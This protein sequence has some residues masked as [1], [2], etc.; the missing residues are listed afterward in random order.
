MR[1]RHLAA[2]FDL[3]A[4]IG[5]GELG[6]QVQGFWINRLDIARRIHMQDK[7]SIENRREDQGHGPADDH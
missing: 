6:G 2:H 1:V 5:L 7:T 3:R 4:K